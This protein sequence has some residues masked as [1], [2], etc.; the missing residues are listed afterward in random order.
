MANIL[1]TQIIE[2]GNRNSIVKIVGVL[3]TGDVSATDVVAPA[4]FD[5]VPLVQE[6]ENPI[7]EPTDHGRST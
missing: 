3:D 2:D 4:S 6:N 5:P 7:P 1:E